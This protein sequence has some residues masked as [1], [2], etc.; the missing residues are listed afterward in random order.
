[1]RTLLI[2]AALTLG[3]SVMAQNDN[4]GPVQITTSNGRTYHNV[5]V[6]RVQPDGLIV[7]YQPTPAG[8]LGV[9]KLNFSVL[10]DQLRNQ[11]G[12]DAQRAQAFE[13]QQARANAEWRSSRSS[14]AAA[15]FERYRNLAEENRAIG[16]DRYTSYLIFLDPNG[17]V[18]AQGYTG[19]V[20]PYNLLF[21]GMGAADLS[22]AQATS[23][24][25]QTP[26]GAAAYGGQP[27][28]QPGP[29]TNAPQ[30]SGNQ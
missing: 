22:S 10:P 5:V 2:S 11:Y 4:G 18:S 1:M 24:A 23:G 17:H 28:M 27:G 14:S 13:A 9:A 25:Q 3:C 19:S 21:P 16:G 7:R 30:P 29:A 26:P 20:P 12:Y 15:W 6:E 8:G